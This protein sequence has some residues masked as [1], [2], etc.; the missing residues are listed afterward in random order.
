MLR[1]LLAALG[2]LAAALVLL[3]TALLVW[4][5]PE[6]PRE[7]TSGG[8]LILGVAVVDVEA[9]VLRRDQDV[10]IVGG[11]IASTGITGSVEV[12]EPVTTID[13]AGKY[14]IPG[15]WDMH[16]HS[17]KLASQ[18]QHPLFIAN[19]ITG[20]REMWGCMSEPD[21]FFAC[22]DDR[23]GWNSALADHRGLSPRYIGQS[24]FQINGGKEVP[25]GYPEFFKA[26]NESEAREL[27]NYYA[28]AGADILKAYTELSPEAYRALAD[29]A[30][31]QGL[32]LDGHRPI[33]VSLEDMLAAGQRSVEHARLFLFECYANADEFRAL[34]DPLAAYTPTLRERLIDEH[35]YER[36]R[37]LI[38]KLADSSTWWTPT[39]Q[40]LKMPALASD[41]DYRSDPRLKYVPFLYRK[42]MWMPDA[43]RKL[44]D[45]FD[46][47]GRN[48]YAA[49]YQL[50]LQHVGQAHA[51][52]A[53]ILTGTDTFDTYVF[54]GFSTHDE[55]ADL[56]SAGLS[57]AD[58][59]K[60]A[61]IDAAVFSGVEREYGSIVAG[62]AADMILLDGDP[63]LDIRNT[64]RIAGVFFNG[65]F[66]DRTSLNRLLQFA[67]QRANSIHGNLH[68][69]W[70]AVRSPLLRVQFAD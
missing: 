38:G 28:A 12:P 13:G 23:Q 29:E 35:D 5:L 57:S 27:V 18:Y 47:S 53:K 64:R 1:N 36:C 54:P 40:T 50:A 59:L 11:R 45:G 8:F 6:M 51:S 37:S 69:L 46:A 67:E 55:L 44:A 62:K 19:G 4:P 2:M 58:A 15:L 41:P 22:M 63:L 56:V 34:P 30:R 7:G 16:T 33:K 68:I 21:P 3:L 31:R 39:L 14:L 26:R 9:G 66:F 70:R 42:L 20:V 32:W 65:Q 52:G 48:V 49:M 17:T 60:T 24:S 10:L 43:D 25:D 61:T